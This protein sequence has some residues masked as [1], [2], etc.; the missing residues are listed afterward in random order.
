MEYTDQ[1]PQSLRLT[2]AFELIDPDQFDCCDRMTFESRGMTVD[3]R[4]IGASHVIV[5]TRG[6]WVHSE[7]LA[8]MT[9]PGMQTTSVMDYVDNPLEVTQDRMYYEFGVTWYKGHAGSRYVR[10]FEE[11]ARERGIVFNFP[12]G[13]L[14]D[15]PKT[16]VIPVMEGDY[17]YTRTVHSYPASRDVSGGVVVVSESI[18]NFEGD[19]SA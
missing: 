16:I 3:A 8:C 11:E 13:E 2:H 5:A 17:L 19:E 12:Q 4:I 10:K 14:V 1:S 6:E 15:V 9:V 7:V 18:L